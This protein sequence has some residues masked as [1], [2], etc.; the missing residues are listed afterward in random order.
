MIISILNQLLTEQRL[1]KTRVAKQLSLPRTFVEGLITNDFQD[2]RMKYLEKI[3][4]GLGLT[5]ISDVLIVLPFELSIQIE[6]QPK[7]NDYIITG[8]FKIN[9]KELIRFN[10]NLKVQKSLHYNYY[11]FELSR[12]DGKVK[13]FLD[14]Y[15]KYAIRAIEDKIYQFAKK[16]LGIKNSRCWY[17]L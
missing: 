17:Y 10:Y 1:T 3:I 4:I 12:K 7:E 16:S 5:S 13:D 6:K 2:V 9:R 11:I 8:L 14:T 15:N